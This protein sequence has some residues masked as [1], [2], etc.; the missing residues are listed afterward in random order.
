M[1]SELENR[2]ERKRPSMMWVYTGVVLLYIVF[3]AFFD[4]LF[5]GA[6]FGFPVS[7]LAQSFISL[8]PG[9]FALAVVFVVTSIRLNRLYAKFE[10]DDSPGFIRAL[11]AF[12]SRLPIVYGFGFFLFAFLT[13]VVIYIIRLSSS[14]A[15]MAPLLF[16]FGISN[17]I[18]G[19]IC[20]YYIVLRFI[21]RLYL[22]FA[23]PGRSVVLRK[24]LG[25]IAK[26][27]LIGV[28]A[29][30][31]P[32]IIISLFTL[33][34]CPSASSYYLIG[35]I[36]VPS[37]C[38]VFLSLFLYSATVRGMASS[39]VRSAPVVV[40]GG[41][42]AVT[43]YPCGDE[44]GELSVVIGKSLSELAATIKINREISEKL[45]D[46]SLNLIA[47]ATEQAASASQQASAVTETSATVTEITQT[48]AKTA[49]NTADIK[50]RAN[51][52]ADILS[53]GASKLN[54]A[55]G[56]I[57]SLKRDV[58]ALSS[59]ADELAE[60][61]RRV[62]SIVALVN[63]L[64]EQSAVLALNAS[65]EAAKAGEAG[66]GFDVVAREVKELAASSKE[67]TREVRRHLSSITG[68]IADV[69][70]RVDTGKERTTSVLG[71]ASEA[72][73]AIETTRENVSQV[74]VMAGQIAAGTAQ[75]S[76]GLG[77][78][79]D[80]VAQINRSALENAAGVQQIEEIS[81]KIRSLSSRLNELARADD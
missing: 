23:V 72:K 5:G 36:V 38:M 32:A 13:S 10:E 11:S 44:I 50:K 30:I 6:L 62:D 4:Y 16:A 65:I 81:E 59:V 47:T 77:Q 55:V 31:V 35:L 15:S 21:P 64:A 41:S 75:Q 34:A 58:D 69:S 78:V 43:P 70:A 54:N 25:F 73:E 27:L 63:D 2:I 53:A 19:G 7:I 14:S 76:Q 68:L 74:V 26:L 56:E 9:I 28:L 20:T 39:I 79:A 33:V 3:V 48:S 42:V 49:E 61:A 8:I 46:T 52:N 51:E 60:Q 71:N 57:E 12:L 45:K 24:G 22:Y 67:A 80:A 29:V 40:K 1:K 37:L 17:S 66:R 18:L